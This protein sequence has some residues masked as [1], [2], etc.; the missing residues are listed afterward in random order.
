MSSGSQSNSPSTFGVDTSAFDYDYEDYDYVKELVVSP[1]A[2][3]A[4]KTRNKVSAVFL[5][6]TVVESKN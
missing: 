4:T 3:T 6:W 1:K 5:L 2:P